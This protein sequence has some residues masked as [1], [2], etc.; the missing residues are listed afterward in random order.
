MLLRVYTLAILLLFA[1]PSGGWTEE[2]VLRFS[3]VVA[4]G[5]PKGQGAL[6]LKRLVEARLAGRVRVEIYPNSELF[7]DDNEIKALLAGEVQII[8]PSL[9]KFSA[10]T[11]KFQ[12]FDL[13]FLFDSLPALDRFQAG[14]EGRR[15]LRILETHNILGLAYWHNG[16]KQ[17]SATR[18][19]RRPED[20]KGLKVRIQSSDVL[21]EIFLTLGAEPH[22]MAFADVFSALR[23]GRVDGA[24]NPWSNFYT[25]R[26]YE[27]QRYITETNHGVLD[28]MIVV[29]ANFWNGLPKDIRAELERIIAIVTT[30]VN[31]KAEFLNQRDRQNILTSGCCE[32]LPLSH[33]DLARWRQILAPV[34]K[35]F[36]ADIG[37][38]L[39]RAAQT[40][41]QAR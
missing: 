22:K 20:V 37:L 5:T 38:D 28:Y 13:P 19:L 40:A 29:N 24:E 12:V 27:V 15:L 3:H 2:I 31:R 36:E 23:S 41:N 8:A 11:R 18:P 30:E 1:L 9:S 39:I 7:G 6:M 25:Q 34:W 17:L 21:H 35:R 16:L 4:E 10:Y 33:D 26:F 14:P 32:V